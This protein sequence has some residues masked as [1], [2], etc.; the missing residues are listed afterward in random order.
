MVPRVPIVQMEK[1]DEAWVVGGTTE[2]ITEGTLV[3]VSIET[4][5][6]ADKG[7]CLAAGDE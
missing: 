1:T 3:V 6:A 2:N 5:I 7:N 4:E